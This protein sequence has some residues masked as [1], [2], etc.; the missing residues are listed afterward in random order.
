MAALLGLAVAACS[1]ARAPA[2]RAPGAAGTGT[3]ASGREAPGPTPSGLAA[4]RTGLPGT[5][6]PGPGSPGSVAP[7]PGPTEPGPSPT[8]FDA[9]WESTV[10]VEAAVSP[11]CV[12]R[13]AT[14]TVTVR[15]VPKG[16]VA[17]HAIY[18]GSHGGAPPPFG[19]GYGGNASGFANGEGVYRDTWTV[20]AQAP[21]GPAR[22]DVVVSDGRGFGY[23]GPGFYVAAARGQCPA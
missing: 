17:Y 9:P 19:S 20:S 8:P 22:V 15:T 4:G 16:A 1:P 5:S 12:L 6:A 23:A 21:V 18:A 2:G 13:G 11:A 7:S 3:P 10:P 14:A